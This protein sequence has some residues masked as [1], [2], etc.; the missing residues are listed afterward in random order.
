MCLQALDSLTPF[1][2][3]DEPRHFSPVISDL[4][5]TPGGRYDAQFRVDFDPTRG[6]M[7]AIGTL[8]KLKPYREYFHHRSAIFPLSIFRPPRSHT[9]FPRPHRSSPRA[10]RLRRHESPR[11]EYRRRFQLRSSRA[12]IPKSGRANH[13]QRLL[14]RPR[15]RIPAPLARHRAHRKSIPRSV[16]D[17]EPRLRWESAAA[18]E[19]VLT[20]IACRSFLSNEFAISPSARR[21]RCCGA[22]KSRRSNLLDAVLERIEQLN[23]ELNAFIT[24]AAERAR[25]DARRAEREI[26]RGKHR[27]PLHGIPLPHQRQYRNARNP[28]HGR[29]ENSREFYSCA[30]CRCRGGVAAEPAR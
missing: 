23:P 5:V 29:I 21:R 26:A 17:R 8:L 1:A 25:A 13:L 2:F 3:Q 12:R 24:V 30:R 10:R 15:L 19:S 20:L 6:Q 16:V 28:H 4:R 22:A 27:G 14:L 9:N 7:T 18:G 11:M